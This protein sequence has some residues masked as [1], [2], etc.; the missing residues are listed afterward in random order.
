MKIFHSRSDLQSSNQWHTCKSGK[1]LSS[2]RSLWRHRKTCRSSTGPTQQFDFNADK[3][4]SLGQKRPRAV[5]IPRFDVPPHKSGESSEFPKNPKIQALLEEIVNDNTKDP[6]PSTTQAIAKKALQSPV[7]TPRVFPPS[8]TP[9]VP[10][11]PS[12]SP[13]PAAVMRINEDI[14][15]Y[16]DESDTDDSD[17]TTDSIDITDIKTPNVKLLPAT[18]AGLWDRFNDLFCEF[19]HDK[20]RKHRNELVFLLDELKRQK[21]VS[22]KLLTKQLTLRISR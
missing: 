21:G 3:I 22:R 19:I 13:P 9:L 6:I 1:R 17:N 12:M 8:P 14:V 16:S 7:P 15:E 2:Y 10:L 4:P 5:E 20:R 11:V 18:V